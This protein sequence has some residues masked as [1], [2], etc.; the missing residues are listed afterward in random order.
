MNVFLT[1]STPGVSQDLHFYQNSIIPP[2]NGQLTGLNG[3]PAQFQ[4][5]GRNVA[6]SGVLGTESRDATLAVF[7]GQNMNGTW[8]LLVADEAS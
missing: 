2:N 8:T 3:T 7:N 4:T 5:D 6:P 1:D